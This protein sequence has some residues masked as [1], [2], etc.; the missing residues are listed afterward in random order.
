MDKLLL[1]ISIKTVE[2]SLLR[3]NSPIL[4]LI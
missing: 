3:H 4:K 2:V 1:K